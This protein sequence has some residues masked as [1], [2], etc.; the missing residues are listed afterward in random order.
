MI[1]ITNIER[2][3]LHDGPGIRTTVFLKGCPMYCP[4]CAN[5]ETQDTLPTLF[6]DEKKCCHCHQCESNCESKAIHFDKQDQFHYDLSK[7]THCDKCVQH[8]PQQALTFMGKQCTIE[9]VLEEVMKDKTYYDVSDGGIT[10]SGGEPLVQKEALL[11]L[12]KE[13]K[14]R[15]LHTA[16]ETALSYSLET[17]QEVEAYVDM[18]LCDLKHIDDTKVANICGG[19]NTLIKANLAYLLKHHKQVEVRIPVIPHFN[20]EEETIKAMLVY[21]KKINAKSVALLPYHTLGK[22]KY[23]KMNQTYTQEGKM[24]DKKELLDLL[25]FGQ[26]MGLQMKIGG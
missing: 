3:A 11:Q 23:D 13:S 25:A 26:E 24:L 16:M 6:Y 15:G 17:L 19:N 9:E 2:F 22:N 8:C 7:C 20:Y 10:I 18:F 14:Q 1:N 21:L 4:W 5:P 12:L